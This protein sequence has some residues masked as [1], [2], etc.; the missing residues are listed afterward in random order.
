MKHHNQLR[1]GSLLTYRAD[2]AQHRRLHCLHAV[3]AAH[4][5]QER[6]RP[7]L[8]RR[9][10]DRHLVCA[11]G[12]RPSARCH[13]RYYILHRK[14]KADQTRSARPQRPVPDRVFR[15]RTDR[16]RVRT[17]PDVSSGDGIQD[18]PDGTPSTTR[19]VSSC[20]RRRRTSPAS[21]PDERVQQHHQCAGAVRVPEGNG[22]P[23]HGRVP[24]R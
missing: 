20:R 14:E 16:A 13:V 3:H 9:L 22:D 15:H 21:L 1:S 23:A 6:I 19:R 12:S 4:P 10:D 24:A 17:V 8:H 11:R 5:R 18:R 7:V 2:D